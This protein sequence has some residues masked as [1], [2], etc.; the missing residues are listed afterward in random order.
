MM[1]VMGKFHANHSQAGF[2]ASQ[3][4]AAIRSLVLSLR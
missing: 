2:Y 4:T 1:I 3:I